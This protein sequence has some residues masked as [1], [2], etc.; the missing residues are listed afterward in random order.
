[1]RD[2]YVASSSATT[3]TTTFKMVTR[4]SA[5]AAIRP[6]VASSSPTSTQPAVL[7][8][9]S[10][11][12][13]PSVHTNG[14]PLRVSPDAVV[15]A[16][17]THSVALEDDDSVYDQD[18]LNGQHQARR[19]SLTTPYQN[20]VL[21]AIIS[22]TR[23]PSTA[24]RDQV[25]KA[26]GLS[27]RQVQV[28]I[29]VHRLVQ[30]LTVVLVALSLAAPLVQVWFQNQRQKARKMFPDI[31]L[32][33]RPFPL[34]D[35]LTQPTAS[36]GP[37]TSHPVPSKAAVNNTLKLI[38][39][40]ASGLRAAGIGSTTQRV[41]A[42]TIEI[43]SQYCAPNGGP[44]PNLRSSD[45]AV[46]ADR[47]RM[48]PPPTP[49]KRSSVRAVS[50]A[51]LPF[52]SDEFR[53]AP[54]DKRAIELASNAR[55]VNEQNVVL[56][57][58]RTPPPIFEYNFPA[59][60]SPDM[61]PPPY[62]KPPVRHPVLLDPLIPPD[63][64]HLIPRDAKTRRNHGYPDWCAHG[65]EGDAALDPDFRATLSVRGIIGRR[66][67]PRWRDGPV[68]RDVKRGP[69]CN[70]A[71]WIWGCDVRLEGS[72]AAYA[73]A[74]EAAGR[75]PDWWEWEWETGANLRMPREGFEQ[76][77]GLERSA[78]NRFSSHNLLGHNMDRWGLFTWLTTGTFLGTPFTPEGGGPQLRPGDMS[79]RYAPSASAVAV[80]RLLN[81]PPP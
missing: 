8:W 23:F 71:G 73:A 61:A 74:A 77:L 43:V 68:P 45:T 56:K 58:T 40:I 28:R 39:E 31:D 79:P 36:P 66:S 18:D 49:V 25:G 20:Y 34:D 21:R 48:P 1:M 44:G 3:T 9:D 22:I 2:S 67:R 72:D 50:L 15:P 78:T 52:E 64:L 29:L 62:E 14:S 30:R 10:S 4:E 47:S 26:I 54:L 17:R 42:Q 37:T 7:T 65:P 41:T 13:H 11:S 53:L 33:H 24:L 59:I 46:A 75:N 76:E 80:S 69:P 60:E 70:P 51:P 5:A 12:S 16:K 57:K 35:L 63:P 19:R 55:L 81:H 27:G 38:E 32:D 6:P